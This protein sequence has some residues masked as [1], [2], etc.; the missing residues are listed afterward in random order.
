M[1]MKYPENQRKYSKTRFRPFEKKSIFLGLIQFSMISPSPIGD[2][3]MPPLC[4][5]GGHFPTVSPIESENERSTAKL[6]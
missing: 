5:K 6:H 1:T 4:S 3:Y 2:F